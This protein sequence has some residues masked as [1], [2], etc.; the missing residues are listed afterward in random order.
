MEP[1]I[2][3]SGT[4]KNTIKRKVKT[5]LT[6]G[7]EEPL[8]NFHMKCCGVQRWNRD[9]SGIQEDILLPNV[10]PSLMPIK[11]IGSDKSQLKS[12]VAIGLQKPY[13]K[14]KVVQSCTCMM[15]IDFE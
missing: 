15:F 2:L 3:H 9:G 7:V 5:Y 12:I 11:E 1:V 10:L 4:L 14:M 8:S 13:A 6:Y